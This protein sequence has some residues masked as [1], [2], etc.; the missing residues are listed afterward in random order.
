LMVPARGGGHRNV[1]YALDLFHED[2]ATLGC[3]SGGYDLRR[4]FV[5]LAVGDGASKDLLRWITHIPGDV[6][7]SYN[8]PPWPALCQAVGKLR[9]E[10]RDDA[11]V[12]ALAGAASERGGSVENRAEG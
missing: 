9:I 3:A 6:F 2:L 7:D 5:S 8:S 12:I 11:Q 4:S 1:S 10:L